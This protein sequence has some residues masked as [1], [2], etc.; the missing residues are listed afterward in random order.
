MN[1]RDGNLFAEL[2]RRNVYKVAIAYAVVAGLLV[3]TATQVFPFFKTPNW[4]V[5]LVVLLF[6][7]GFPVALILAWGFELT[8]QGL[9]RAENVDRQSVP[10]PGAKR[11]WLYLVIA[12]GIRSLPDCAQLRRRRFIWFRADRRLRP[13]RSRAAICVEKVVTSAANLH[14]RA[15]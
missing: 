10:A 3:Q 14:T 4:A 12:S 5:R 8:P 6:I 9:K 7:I 15:P 2:K 11:T 1:G 13:H